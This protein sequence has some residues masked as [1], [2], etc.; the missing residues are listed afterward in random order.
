MGNENVK[1]ENLNS[2][3]VDMEGKESLGNIGNIELRGLANIGNSSFINSTIQCLSNCKEFA[4]MFI[5]AKNTFVLESN[6]LLQRLSKIILYLYNKNPDTNIN[7]ILKEFRQH[8]IQQLPK[9][10]DRNNQESKEI[11][12]DLLHLINQFSNEK[13]EILPEHWKN[14][15]DINQIV[16]E[17]NSVKEYWDNYAKTNI[18][19]INELFGGLITC[20]FNCTHCDKA[21]EE[22]NQTNEPFLLFEVPIPDVFIMNLKIIYV[23]KGTIERN[24]INIK[25]Y[26]YI[27]T[28][29]Q[30]KIICKSQINETLFNQDSNELFILEIL[31]KECKEINARILKDNEIIDISPFLEQPNKNEKKIENKEL[32]CVIGQYYVPRKKEKLHGNSLQNIFDEKGPVNLNKQ[33]INNTSEQNQLN[34][35]GPI[36]KYIV[37]IPFKCVDRDFLVCSGGQNYSTSFECSNY[38]FVFIVTIPNPQNNTIDSKDLLFFI[39]SKLHPKMELS[40]YWSKKHRPR[41]EFYFLNQLHPGKF[42][43]YYDEQNVENELQKF[44]VSNKRKSFYLFYEE[45]RDKGI[46]FEPTIPILDITE[47]INIDICLHTWK[48]FQREKKKC[49]ICKSYLQYKKA[50]S[51]LPEYLCINLKKDIVI[52]NNN[53]I[54]REILLSEE[55]NLLPYTSTSSVEGDET[56]KYIFDEQKCK[57][58]L[59]AINQ[60]SKALFRDYYISFIKLNDKWYLFDNK[61]VREISFSEIPNDKTTFMVY[62]RIKT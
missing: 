38:P 33:E 50:L 17:N 54:N 4:K 19:K 58:K 14:I 24:V 36:K 55:L 3:L 34:E 29:K 35:T 59:I 41:W 31:G 48:D 5:S 6:P 57:Y 16:F 2:E 42:E 26:G 51:K 8:L 52:N 45:K 39:G 10:N 21:K 22:F 46:I 23:E 60:I 32:F 40:E 11:L 27:I 9:Y 47:K 20:E 13:T 44:F 53:K 61:K 62:E 7:D 43:D 30:L 12:I 49:E 25:T 18:S 15:E 28:A 37:S 1:N 56:E